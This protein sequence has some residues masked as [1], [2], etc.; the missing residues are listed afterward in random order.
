MPESGY[1]TVSIPKYI[2]ESIKSYY[3]E[4]KK[5]LRDR[6]INSPSKLLII[7]L[8]EKAAAYATLKVSPTEDQQ[9]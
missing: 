8:T 3:Q 9:Q 7:W 6:G 4:H 2:W 1:T 5:E